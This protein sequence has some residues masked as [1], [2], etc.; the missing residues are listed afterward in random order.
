[1]RHW[2]EKIQVAT[3]AK[4]QKY[5]L[6]PCTTD[7]ISAATY[8]QLKDNISCNPCATEKYDLQLVRN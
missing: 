2:E 3:Y 5:Q 7:K 4:F 1:M 8:V 6:H